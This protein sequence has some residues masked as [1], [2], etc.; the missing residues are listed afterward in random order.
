M[1]ILISTQTS[2]PK[3]FLNESEQCKRDGVHAFF[4]PYPL[5]RSQEQPQPLVSMK[6]FAYFVVTLSHHP[7]LVAHSLSPVADAK[8]N[9]SPCVLV[10][11]TESI[12][13]G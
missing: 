8:M 3:E 13:F 9:F 6:H 2:K 4:R 7:Q 5:K 1:I 12:P 10:S 11:T